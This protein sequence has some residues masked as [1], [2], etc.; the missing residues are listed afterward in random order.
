MVLYG[1][2]ESHRI[3]QSA[4]IPQF[5]GSAWNVYTTRSRMPVIDF[6]IIAYL[7]DDIDHEIIA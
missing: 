4:L 3:K 1:L 5:I 7:L 2:T 6:L